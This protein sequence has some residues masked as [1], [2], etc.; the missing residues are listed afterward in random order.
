[1]GVSGS[2][3]KRPIHGQAQPVVHGY[4]SRTNKKRKPHSTPADAHTKR[5]GKLVEMMFMVKAS[6]EGLAVAKP[7]GD[8]RRYDFI[9]DA[10]TRLWRV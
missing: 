3:A 10:G 8:S 5:R 4:R 1:M 2:T 7:Y 6:Q 9:L